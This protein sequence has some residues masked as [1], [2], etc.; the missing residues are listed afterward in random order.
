MDVWIFSVLRPECSLL[1]EPPT[2]HP[3]YLIAE[4]KLPGVVSGAFGPYGPN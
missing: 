1:V 3:E 2:G 4:I